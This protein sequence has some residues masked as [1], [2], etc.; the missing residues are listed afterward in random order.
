VWIENIWKHIVLCHVVRKAMS[1]VEV[2]GQ[3]IEEG[4]VVEEQKVG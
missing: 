2:A 3:V 1:G 4:S